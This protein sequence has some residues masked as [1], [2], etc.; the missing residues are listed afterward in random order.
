MPLNNIDTSYADPCIFYS[1]KGEVNILAEEFTTGELDGRICLFKY[2]KTKGF[3][4]PE[5]I[6][7]NGTHFSYP[8]IYKE[9]NK[10]HVLVENA[11]DGPL[12][13]YEY[14]EVREEIGDGKVIS[15][16]PILDAT[17]LKAQGKYWLFGTLLGN[18]RF[19]KLHIYYADN[20]SGPYKAHA[21]NPVKNNL[22]GSRPAGNFFE[23]DGCIYRPSQNCGAYYGES[24]TINKI[25]KLSETE[26]AEEEYMVIKANNN[27]EYNMGIH[28]INA[29]GNYIVVDG[30]KGH[31]QPFMQLI[32]AVKRLFRKNKNKLSCVAYYL[33]SFNFEEYAVAC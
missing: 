6:L 7:K 33:H 19:S 1:N 10:S 24:I 25:L 16:L 11:F 31:F 29:A 5:T 26:F 15:N 14:D 8:L 27:G 12:V 9:N 13:S 22:N 4:T 17:I 30:Q 2:D 23:V 20:F 32:R 28:T 3:S 21:A 18:G